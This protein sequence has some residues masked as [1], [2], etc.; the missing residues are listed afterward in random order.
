MRWF[1]IDPCYVFHTL[2]AYDDGDS[3]IVD[4]VRHDRMFATVL[5]G[6]NEGPSTLTRFTLDLTTGRA[7]EHRFDQRAQEFP[8]HDERLT[9]RRH[10]YGYAVGFEDGVTGDAVIRHDLA[11]GTHQVRSL[12]SGRQASEFCFVPRPGGTAE[13]DGV[14]MGYVHDLAAGR[15]SLTVLDAA[16]LEDVGGVELPGP[17][18]GRVPR[19]LGADDCLRSVIVGQSEARQFGWRARQASRFDEHAGGAAGRTRPMADQV[20]PPDQSSTVDRVA[21]ELRRSLLE[22][23][24]EGGAPL[25]EVALAESLG[26]SRPTVREAL[27]SLVA[28]GLAT[29]EPNRGV[30]VA[31][32]DPESVRDVFRARAVLEVAGV[33]HWRAATEEA[34]EH[35]RS[36]LVDYTAAV[37]EGTSYESSTSST[38]PCTRPSSD[39]S[40]RRGSTP[41]PIA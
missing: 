16:T 29:R 17:C 25:R 40:A 28:T 37:A 9:G 23:E 31:E 36:T 12:G 33:R 30:S 7:S 18:A 35:V 6:P 39:C 2:N 26:V 21:D 5:D 8:R 38:W 34:R 1:E 13:D 32:P 24:V 41:W 10:R 19:Q 14:L 11:A 3:V 27:A 22:G 15:S 4:V 20:V